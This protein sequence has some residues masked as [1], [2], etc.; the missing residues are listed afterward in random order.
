MRITSPF[1]AKEWFRSHAHTGVDIAMPI[2]TPLKSIKQAVV[3]RV[4][5]YG[6][7]NI[8]KGV[9]LKL[10]DGKEVI[11]GHLSEI[12]VKAGQIVKGGE[13]IGLSGN[14]G[15]STGPHLHF[16][17]KDHGQFI[18]PTPYLPLLEQPLQYFFDTPNQEFLDQPIFDNTQGWLHHIIDKLESLLIFW[19]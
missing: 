10:S 4:M 12:H 1:G 19:N 7:Q 6:N 15:H 9:V 18:D 13:I 2:G 11:Y 8:G 5:D 17:I 14:T 16:A 3:E